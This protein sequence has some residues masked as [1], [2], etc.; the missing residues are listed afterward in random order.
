MKVLVI[1]DNPTDL[2]LIGAVLTISGHAV[3]GRNAA[4]GAIEAVAADKPDIILMDLRLP[5]ID[6]LS[7]ARQ[8]K[9]NAATR[10]IPI[11]AMTAYPERYSREE[12]LAAG[13]DAFIVKP[14]DTRELPNKLENIA[15]MEPQ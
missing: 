7:L 8:L 5:G 4:E 3:D 13:C 15:G 1:E 14:I 2:K 11:V 12:L 10:H 6:G 9:S